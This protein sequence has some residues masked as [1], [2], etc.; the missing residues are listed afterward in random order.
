MADVARRS[1]R[2]AAAKLP[3]STTAR[4]T[5]SWSRLG[6]PICGPSGISNSLNVISNILRVFRMAVNAYLRLRALVPGHRLS[7]ADTETARPAFLWK[8]EGCRHV[9]LCDNRQEGR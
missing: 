4:K 7:P 2:P 3:V 9:R 6:V 1:R 8:P 5:W